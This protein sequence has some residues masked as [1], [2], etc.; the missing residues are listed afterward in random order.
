MRWDQILGEGED[1][2]VIW[3]QYYLLVTM[4]TCEIIFED[5]FFDKI[6]T[7]FYC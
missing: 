7:N 5:I 6:K 4:L 2:C 3:S 1:G